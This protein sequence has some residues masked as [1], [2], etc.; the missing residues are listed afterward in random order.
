M[1]AGMYTRDYFPEVLN[2][3]TIYWETKCKK[4]Y[5][6]GCYFKIQSGRNIKHFMHNDV[7]VSD[8]WLEETIDNGP[9]TVA[10]SC[11]ILHLIYLIFDIKIR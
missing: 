2:S 10:I 3:E 9:Q 5:A 1:D 7:C 8:T 11:S 6:Y 4:K